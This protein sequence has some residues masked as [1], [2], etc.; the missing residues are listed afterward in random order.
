MNALCR[1][2]TQSGLVSGL[3]PRLGLARFGVDFVTSHMY[4]GNVVADNVVDPRQ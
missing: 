1:P 4:L 3:S 2:T